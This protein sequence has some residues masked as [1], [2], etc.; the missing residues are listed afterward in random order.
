MPWS[1]VRI[2]TTPP[3]SSSIYGHFSTHTCLDHLFIF[4]NIKS[5]FGL[6]IWLA[7]IIIHDHFQSLN[8][9]QKFRI[10]AHVS[11][12]TANTCSCYA[13][14][15]RCSIFSLH[16]SQWTSAPCV[17]LSIGLRLSHLL[18][19]TP[20]WCVVSGRWADLCYNDIGTQTQ[21]TYFQPSYLTIDI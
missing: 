9:F 6:V 1:W 13:A 3:S 10:S 7:V 11:A 18:P 19:H 2:M 12:I 20:L 15:P 14:D 17:D 5:T 21:L 4:T 8:L 16:L